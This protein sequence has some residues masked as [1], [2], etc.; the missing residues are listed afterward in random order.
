MI[1]DLVAR[2]RE[3]GRVSIIM[4][5]HN[6]VHVLQSCD[7]VNLIQDGEITFDK[8]T[9]ETSVE[10]LNDI[11]VEEYRR[12]RLA[13]GIGGR[14]AERDGRREVT[15][16]TASIGVDFGTLSGRA[17]VVR[18]G[19]RR[20]ARHR[21]CTTTRTAS[22]TARC[23]ATGAPLP[24][25]VGAAGPRGLPRGAAR[26][27]CPA[28]MRAAGVAPG[29]VVGIGTDFTASTPLPVL[30]DGTPLCRLPDFAA[31]R[32][33][34]RSCGST[35]PPSAQADRINA[36]AARARRAVA[37]ALRRADLLG[38]GVRQGAAGARGGPGGLRA[39]GALGR[40]APTGSSGSSAARETRNIC[41]AGYKAHPPGRRATRR[42]TSCARST[43]ASPT[44]SPTSSAAP[45]SPLGAR[46]GGLTAQA[47]EWTGL[48]EGIAVAVGNVDAHVTAPA[49]RADRARPDARGHGHLDLPRDER[50]PRSPRCRACAA[51]S[52]AGSSPGCGATRPGQSGVG[53]I[54]G[55][56][57]EHAV[58][59]RYHEQARARGLDV[60]ELP[61]RARRRAGGRRARAGRA[62]LG[63]RQPLGAR[64]PRAERADRR[65]DARHAR[66][67][68]LPRADRGDRVRHAH[69][70]RRRSR[71][72]GVPVQRA[73]RRRR[74]A[75]EPGDHADLRRRHAACR[76]T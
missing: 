46:A 54:F 25:A 13:H 39:D 75:Q 71:T 55:W 50:R 8:P 7:R 72:P 38:V 42:R 30:A 53:D 17:V 10:E 35:T 16:A 33:P 49:A 70:P 68:R 32:T 64:R 20:G 62:G 34:T 56:F 41:T 23:P 57:V 73:V 61:L 74:A 47:A 9:A 12:A 22:S 65:A 37:G 51:S 29:D 44:S 27:R 6:Y 58:P 28:A 21:P 43:S 45:L 2:L 18:G 67:G 69:D 1:L 66:R 48:P 60:H 3:E 11:V 40:G 4:I 24:P 5:A 52:T 14:G 26:R 59:P 15:G 36:L 31:A 76:C 19:R 63:Q